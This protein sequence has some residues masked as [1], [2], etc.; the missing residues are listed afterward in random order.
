M[1]MS[2]GKIC[3]FCFHLNEADASECA[4]CHASFE[5][6]LRTPVVPSELADILAEGNLPGSRNRTPQGALALHIVSEKSPLIVTSKGRII[7]GR[8]LDDS[9]TQVVDLKPYRAHLLGVSRQHAALMITD[10]EC[11]LE[12]LDSMNGTWLNETRLLSHQ[13]VK[14]QD[15]D[16]IRLGLLLMFVSRQT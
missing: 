2:Q 3:V 1:G 16:L 8:N 13:P 12:D 5:V 15:G 10:D 7:L 9:E 14:I 6:D 4:H 11:T